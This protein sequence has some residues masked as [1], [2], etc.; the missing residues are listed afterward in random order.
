MLLQEGGGV[1]CRAQL[2]GLIDDIRRGLRGQRCDADQETLGVLDLR[3]A[4][5]VLEA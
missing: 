2:G 5:T 1:T 3:G 4:E